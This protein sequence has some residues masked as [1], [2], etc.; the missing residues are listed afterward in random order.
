QIRDLAELSVLYRRARRGPALPDDD[1]GG[2]RGGGVG[3]A[4]AGQAQAVAA[5]G[6]EDLVAELAPA[7]GWTEYTAA[8]QVLLAARVVAVMPHALDRL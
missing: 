1:D 2:G 5:A 7:L 3:A 6:L 8:A 4:F